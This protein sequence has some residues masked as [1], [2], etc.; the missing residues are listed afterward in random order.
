M[1][2]PREVLQL[3]SNLSKP[4]LLQEIIVSRKF[5]FQDAITIADYLF[6]QGRIR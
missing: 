2:N 6:F 4:E 5:S 1:A 3:Y